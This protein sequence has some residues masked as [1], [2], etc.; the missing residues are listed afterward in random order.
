MELKLLK[1]FRLLNYFNILTVSVLWIEYTIKVLDSTVN[2]K[3]L[4]N[5]SYIL[6][7]I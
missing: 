7:E 4:L 5:T 3:H 6:T 1:I 2:K